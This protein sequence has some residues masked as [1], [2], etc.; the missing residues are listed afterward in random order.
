MPTSNKYQQPGRDE[1]DRQDRIGL[2]VRQ[3]EDRRT[4]DRWEKLLETE[5]GLRRRRNAPRGRRLW[6]PL[7][8]VAA[9]LLLLLLALPLLTSPKGPAILTELLD[10]REMASNY[11]TELP[12]EATAVEIAGLHQSY[13]ERDYAAVLAAGEKLATADALTEQEKYYVALAAFYDGRLQTAIDYFKPLTEVDL[14]RSVSYYHIGLSYLRANHV[15]DGLKALREVGEDSP[16]HYR[17]A[18]ELL[19]AEW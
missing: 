8:A 14:Y 9:T 7:L 12:R 5:H 15:A 18:Q 13:A 19:G 17:Q 1:E 4:R 11:R 16:R 3:R 2:F 10:Q 6:L